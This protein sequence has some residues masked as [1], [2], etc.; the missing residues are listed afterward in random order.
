MN[1]DDLPCHARTSFMHSYMNTYPEKRSFTDRIFGWIETLRESDSLLLKLVL[2]GVFV[3]LIWVLVSLSLGWRAEVAVSGGMYR[4]GVV[5]TPRFVNPV[6]AVSRADKDLVELVYDGLMTV[7]SD[8]MLIPNI[9]ESVNVSA[10]G[11][12]YN[13]VLKK[14]ISFHDETPLTARDVV[15]TVG[16]ITDPLVTSPLRPNFDGVSVEQVGEY[17]VNFV[18]K[19]PYSPFLENL[20]FGILPAH[21]WGNV[22]VEEFPFSQRNSEPV[23]SGPYMVDDIRR[24][25]SGIPEEYVLRPH[26]GYHRGK[27][28]IESFVVSF[29]PNEEKLREA[30][31]GKKIDGILINEVERVGDITRDDTTHTLITSPLPRTFALFINQNKSAALR[32][33]GV[34]KALSIAIDRDELVATVLNGYALPEYGPLPHGFGVDSAT[35]EVSGDRIEEAHAILESSGW[36]LNTESGVWEKTIDKIPTV[37]ELSISTVNSPRFEAVAE[38]IRKTWEQLGVRV[39]VKQFEQSDLTQGVIRPRDY[40]VLLFGTHVGRAL[41]L[42]SFWHSSQRNDPGLNVALYANITTDALLTSARTTTDIA[43]RNEALMTFSDEIAKETPALF[44]YQ[45]EL[46]YLFPTRVQNAHFSGVGDQYER[47]ASVHD[48]YIDTESIWNFL[49]PQK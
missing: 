6:L 33:E 35:P 39:S 19:E 47:F 43:K 9:A 32:D 26:E 10:D 23:G 5:G 38:F 36:K 37:L 25:E 12:T 27:P 4:E 24:S 11:L 48:W 18:L 41:D 49:A 2:L 42:Y 40:E 29:Y 30:F 20:T 46:V 34:R 44:L 45:P 14:N 8:G 16:R 31:T 1:N 28:R 3:S 7:G 22:S 13:V 21:I 15:F 17:E